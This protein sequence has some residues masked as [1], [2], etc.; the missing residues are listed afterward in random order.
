MSGT[1]LKD[2][3]DVIENAAAVILCVTKEMVNDLSCRTIVAMAQ[4]INVVLIPV[5]LEENSVAGWIEDEL[6]M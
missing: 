6:P 1:A 4:K 3:V 2:A 5:I